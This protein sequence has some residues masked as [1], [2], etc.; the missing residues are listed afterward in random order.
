MSSMFHLSAQRILDFF[1][2]WYL[3]WPVSSP[4]QWTE[5]LWSE[6]FSLELLYNKICWMKGFCNEWSKFKELIN[7]LL[8]ASLSTVPVLF[9]WGPT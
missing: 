6:Y 8:G 3:G 1:Q 5:S 4:T 2:R 9:S 7:G